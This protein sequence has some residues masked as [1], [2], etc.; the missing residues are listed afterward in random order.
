MNQYGAGR[1][2]PDATDRSGSGRIWHVRDFRI[3]VRRCRPC[4]EINFLASGVGCADVLRTKYF[5]SPSCF[6]RRTAEGL[7]A[8]KFISSESLRERVFAQQGGDFVL[9]ESFQLRQEPRHLLVL[10]ARGLL[11]VDEDSISKW[12][13][14]R[15]PGHRISVRKVDA[16]IRGV[17]QPRRLPRRQ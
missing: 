10:R 9:G 2:R 6:V 7:A 4:E 1:P 16:F 13:S 15:N 8:R 5:Q 14:G 3:V 11:A 17:P 12:E